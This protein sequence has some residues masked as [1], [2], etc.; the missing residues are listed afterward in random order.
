VIRGFPGKRVA[1][2]ARGDN[3]AL[4]AAY[5][6]PLAPDLTW[7]ALRDGFFSFQQFLDRPQSLQTSFQ[8]KREDK[9]RNAPY[10]REIPYLYVPF[11]ALRG[12]DISQRLAASRAQCLIVNPADGD[13]RRM[14]AEAAQRLVRCP[15]V[16][17]DSYED[18]VRLFL[19]SF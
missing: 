1:L 15:V 9:D 14:S 19:N 11:D 16:S 3:A 18:R 10:D 5:A 13:W 2:Y 8:L 4:A 6:I 12:P 7:Y 17:S